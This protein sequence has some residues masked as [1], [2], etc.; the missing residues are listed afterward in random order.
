MTH[1]AW[2][3]N[4]L[5]RPEIVVRTA[6]L[7]DAEQQHAIIELLDSYAREPQVGGVSFSP[8]VR[9]RL[10][11]ELRQQSAGR[12]FLAFHQTQAV[13]VAICFLGFS[14]FYAQ[15]LLNIHDLAVKEGFRGLGIGRQLLAAIET[16]AADHGCCKVTLEVRADN[17]ARRL[18]EDVG[19]RAGETEGS[20]FAFMTKL[21]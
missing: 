21:L 19:F 14:T 6:D 20:A 2:I 3:S 5:E 9:A 16:A 11:S 18:Y 4:M 15:P 8:A 7:D 12:Y 1:T 17:R 13:G 10:I